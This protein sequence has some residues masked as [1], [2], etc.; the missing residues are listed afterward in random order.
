MKKFLLAAF[1]LL[2]GLSSAQSGN[3]DEKIDFKFGKVTKEDFILP[4]DAIQQDAAAYI[5]IDKGYTEFVGNSK[6]WFSLRF[7]RK[8]RIKINNANG[9]DAADF[10][11]PVYR[12]GSTVEK[13]QNLKAVSYNLDNGQITE[14]YLKSDQIF[15]DKYSRNLELRKFSVP[16]VKAGSLVDVTYVLESDFLSNLQ[17][18]TFQGQYPRYWSEYEVDFPQFFH[19]VMIAQ[20]YQP[21]HLRTS[22]EDRMNFSVLIPSEDGIGGRSEMASFSANVQYTRWVMKNVPALK[23]EP[24]TSTLNNH[25]SKIDFQLSQYRFEGQPIRNMMGNWPQMVNSLNNYEDF[26]AS[27]YKGNGFLDEELK[28]VIAGAGSQ[29]DKAKRIYAYVRDKYTC[30]SSRGLYLTNGLKNVIKTKSGNV[31]DINLLLT[32]MLNHEKIETHPLILSTRSHGLTHEIYPLMDRYNYVVAQA[33]I[34]G[35]TYNLDATEPGLP[36]GVLPPQCYNGHARLIHGF[37]PP[38]YLMPDSVEEKKTTQLFMTVS[39]NGEWKGELRSSLGNFESLTMRQIARAKGK[40]DIIDAIKKQV[41][42]EFSI[43]EPTFE[44]IDSGDANVSV[45]YEVKPEVEE[46]ADVIYL[47]P[48]VAEGFKENPFGSAERKYPVE[49][50]YASS[51]MFIANIEIPKGYVVEEIPKSTKVNL[52]ENDGFFEYIVSKD[53]ERVMLRCR[54]VIHKADFIADDYEPLREFF[55]YVVK[56]QQETIVFRK[57][58]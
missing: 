2:A 14:T 37:G 58:K 3:P 18:W 47:N 5:V 20:G 56:K 43:G 29:L 16:G 13:L 48:M 34:D 40:K 32:A 44:N 41:P 49:M 38:V 22:K 7:T 25:I 17:P 28:A 1:V 50:P 51:E 55:S 46:D 10:Q 9:V 33:K 27:L 42:T 45:I 24:F 12:S 21:Y 57:K 15:E 8:M 52:F 26:G 54:L 36:F 39:E 30:T 6:G 53:A 4:P 19:Y 31:A 35:V 11:I 23:E